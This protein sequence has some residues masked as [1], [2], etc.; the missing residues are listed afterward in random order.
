MRA[1][2]PESSCH[3]SDCEGDQMVHALKRMKLEGREVVLTEAATGEELKRK[4]RTNSPMIV[5]PAT[6][7]ERRLKMQELLQNQLRQ[8]K[9]QY[10]MIT[11]GPDIA[12]CG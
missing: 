2:S 7:E 5:Q 12:P 6:E 1:P 11:E 4:S 8:Y 3:S 10:S 9:S